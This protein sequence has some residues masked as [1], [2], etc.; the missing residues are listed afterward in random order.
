MLSNYYTLA[1]LAT[2][3]DAK[4]RGKTIREAYTQEKNV[5]AL[6]VEGMSETLIVSC[7]PDVNT[8]YLHPAFSR[9]RT[10]STN[11][12]KPTQGKSIL[13]VSIQ[14]M[15]RVIAF[16]LQDELTLYAQ[17]FGSRANVLVVDKN[18]QIVDAFKDAR[19]ATGSMYVPRREEMVH[20]VAALNELI[21]QEPTKLVFALLKRASPVLGSTL[22][23]EILFRSEISAISRAKDISGEQRNRLNYFL[24]TMLAER[25]V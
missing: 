15:D 19:S 13:S 6:S 20:D 23:N 3:L 10:N 2:D 16:Q 24:T 17:F 4:L 7:A 8:L 25:R 18:S 14:P 1:I 21:T 9:A 22:T 12:L 5:L 11:V